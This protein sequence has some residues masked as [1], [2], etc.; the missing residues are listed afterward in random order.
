MASSPSVALALGF[1]LLTA[2]TPCVYPMIPITLAIFGAKGVARSRAAALAS[3]YV[4]G[5]AVLF[6]GL[7]VTFG[8]LGKAFGTYL[9]N[10][11]VVV[12]LALFFIAMALSMFG[13]FELA[14]RD[15]EGLAPLALDLADPPHDLGAPVEQREDLVVDRVDLRP[16]RRELGRRRRRRA[17]GTL[18]HDGH[19][20]KA[21]RRYP[22]RR[23]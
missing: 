18:A 13:A 20:L 6:G 15:V 1:G 22:C 23:L 16:Q 7:G 5:I 9:G 3:A 12:P 21:P 4:A 8:L 17:R 11:W 19:G 10:P 14:L 2:L